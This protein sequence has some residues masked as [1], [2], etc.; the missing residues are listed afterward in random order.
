ME[1]VT[2]WQHPFVDVFKKYDAFSSAGHK[3]QV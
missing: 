2:D 1:K 3:G